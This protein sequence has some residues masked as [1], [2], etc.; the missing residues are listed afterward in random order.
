LDC[1]DWNTAP[2]LFPEASVLLR[3]IEVTFASVGLL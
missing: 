1:A 2:T 3:Y